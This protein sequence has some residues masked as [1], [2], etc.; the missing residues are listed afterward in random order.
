M[1]KAT[2]TPKLQ[3]KKVWAGLYGG[4]YDVIVFFSDKPRVEEGD[5]DTSERLYGGK[6]VID[7]DKKLALGSMSL[8]QFYELYPN[9]DI[10]AFAQDNGRP[11]DTVF[12]E[13]FELELEAPVDEDGAFESF[14]YDMDDWL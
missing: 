8:E 10:S 11:K 6:G 2:F 7:E 13:F 5:I 14:D 1:I 12:V 4:H 9:A 3:T